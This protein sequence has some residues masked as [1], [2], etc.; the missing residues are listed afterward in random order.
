MAKG[1]YGRSKKQ[2]VRVSIGPVFRVLKVD[3]SGIEPGDDEAVET[4]DGLRAAQLDRRL[5]TRLGD[6][7][8]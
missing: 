2:L 3:L 7:R 4:R 1:K 8:A 5:G 6:A